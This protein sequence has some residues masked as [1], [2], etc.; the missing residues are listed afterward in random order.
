MTPSRLLGSLSDYQLIAQ[1]VPSKVWP[2]AVAMTHGAAS[3][4]LDRQIERQRPLR[5]GKYCYW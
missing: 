1:A 5:I 2:L 3:G 4:A